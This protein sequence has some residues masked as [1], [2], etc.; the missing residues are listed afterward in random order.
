MVAATTQRARCLFA[1][2]AALLD[3]GLQ[4]AHVVHDPEFGVAVGGH[5]LRERAHE[6]GNVIVFV[7]VIPRL[8]G[9]ESGCS[10]ALHVH[11]RHG[12]KSGVSPAGGGGNYE[13]YS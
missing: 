1:M 2:L 10:H 6:L 8:H 3:H 13:L 9:A 11:R 4:D 5:H 7:F 12:G